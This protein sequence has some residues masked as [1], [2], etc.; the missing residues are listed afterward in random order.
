MGDKN[1]SSNPVSEN[2][3]RVD[4]S[5]PVIDAPA[6]DNLLVESESDNNGKKIKN[7]S[8]PL[9]QDAIYSLFSENKLLLDQE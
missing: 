8:T 6:I 4:A 3:S 9:P 5:A 1:Q 2:M 7:W